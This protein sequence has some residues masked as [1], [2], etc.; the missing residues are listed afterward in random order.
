MKLPFSIEVPVFQPRRHLGQDDTLPKFEKDVVDAVDVNEQK[1]D[2]A[3][4]ASVRAWNAVFI[5]GVFHVIATILI[6]AAVTNTSAL[7]AILRLF[8]TLAP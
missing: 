6:V 7:E 5:L 1:A 8:K 3:I 4:A 2:F